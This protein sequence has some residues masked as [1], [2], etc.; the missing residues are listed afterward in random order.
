[1]VAPRAKAKAKAVVR[2]GKSDRLATAKA[3]PTVKLPL[4]V[5][6]LTVDPALKPLR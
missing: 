2:K 1:V 4:V 5:D 3:N 6:L